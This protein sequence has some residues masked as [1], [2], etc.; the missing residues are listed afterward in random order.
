MK[1]QVLLRSFA[2]RTPDRDAL[3]CDGTIVTYAEWDRRSNQLAAVL[4]ERGV[5]AG[6][7]VILLVSNGVAWPLL[8]LA[9]MKLGALVIPVSTRLTY[10]EVAFIVGDGTPHMLVY[11]DELRAVA[12]GAVQGTA[13]VAAS[14]GELEA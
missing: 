10:H 7:R 12:D 9:V 8:C 3:V 6:D 14:V 4:R 5:R 11:S 1:T 2:Q 13:T